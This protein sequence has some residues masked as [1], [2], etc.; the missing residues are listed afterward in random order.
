MIETYE[1]SFITVRI[2]L[3]CIS[4]TFLHPSP[5]DCARSYILLQ[6]FKSVNEEHVYQV[7]SKSP[8]ISIGLL[9][10]CILKLCPFYP[11]AQARV[12][13]P[14]QYFKSYSEE[15]VYE[16]SSKLL[17]MSI[18]LFAIYILD[19]V[20]HPHLRDWVTVYLPLQYFKS[21]NEKT[22]YQVSSKLV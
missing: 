5:K 19:T 11:E 15:H 18:D 4:E 21:A 2:F 17:S 12:Y 14:L 13:L 1:L 22:V 20:P 7:S 6:Y 10:T 8:S 16:V 9:A 3:T